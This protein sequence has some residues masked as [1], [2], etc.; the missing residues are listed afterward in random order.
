VKKKKVNRNAARTARYRFPGS[1]YALTGFA[2]AVGLPLQL[3]AQ[4]VP[5]PGSTVTVTPSTSI[6]QA[7]GNAITVPRHRLSKQ[8]QTQP[9]T[10]M[11]QFLAV[12]TESISSTE[13]VQ[14][15]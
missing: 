10:T 12:S 8:V 6:Q 2:V 13:P 11:A 4:V 14:A 5:A 15:R 3:Q 1:I 9:S 7:T